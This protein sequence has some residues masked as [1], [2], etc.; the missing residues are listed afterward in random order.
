MNDHTPDTAA[1]SPKPP[2]RRWKRWLWIALITPPVGIVAFCWISDFTTPTGPSDVSY[3]ERESVSVTE[4]AVEDT[5][6]QLPDFAGIESIEESAIPHDMD[7]FGSDDYASFNIRVDI[8]P[9]IFHDNSSEEAQRE[10]FARTIFEHWETAGYEPTI[11]EEEGEGGYFVT[12]EREDGVD[13]YFDAAYSPVQLTVDTGWVRLD[14]VSGSSGHATHE[15]S[16]DLD[17][18]LHPDAEE[19]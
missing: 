2:R 7:G 3:G 10:E 4:E 18:L 5:V 6:E 19:E 15:W 14:P 12:A 16:P 1:E 17:H 8:S 11:S 9:D 13:L